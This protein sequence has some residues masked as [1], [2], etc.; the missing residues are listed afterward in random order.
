MSVCGLACCICVWID[1]NVRGHSLESIQLIFE[2]ESLIWQLVQAD[3]PGTGITNVCCLYPRFNMVLRIKH[4]L[5]KQEPVFSVYFS[6][7]L[8]LRGIM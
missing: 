6:N 4:E 3:L 7:N 1:A 2:T 8:I 5:M